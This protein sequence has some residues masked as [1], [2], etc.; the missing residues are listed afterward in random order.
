MQ[1]TDT[2][3]RRHVNTFRI[4]LYRSVEFPSENAVTS[5]LNA[6]NQSRPT[7]CNGMCCAPELTEPYQPDMNYSMATRKVQGL[8]AV[9]FA[10]NGLLTILG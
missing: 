7:P 10:N 8:K 3:H 6:E 4:Y 5:Q 1:Q 2:R 9:P